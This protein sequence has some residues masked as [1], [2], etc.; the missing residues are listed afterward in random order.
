MFSSGTI[1]SLARQ[2][3]ALVAGPRAGRRPPRSL[4]QAGGSGGVGLCPRCGDFVALRL[5]A[6]GGV[7]PCPA[8]GRPIGGVRPLG[9]DGLG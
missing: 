2:V 4:L 9:G 3:A 6:A 5:P 1:V 7:A 8:C